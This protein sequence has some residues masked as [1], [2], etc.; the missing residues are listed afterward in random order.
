MAESPLSL[1]AIGGE[2]VTFGC[3]AMRSNVTGLATLPALVV[4]GVAKS[5]SR[6]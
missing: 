3:G 5:F 1:A 6:F 2:N 4:L